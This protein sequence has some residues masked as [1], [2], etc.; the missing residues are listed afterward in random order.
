MEKV[1]GDDVIVHAG[2]QLVTLD[3]RLIAMQRSIRRLWIALIA[4]IAVQV[5]WAV[6]GPEEFARIIRSLIDTAV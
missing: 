3:E 5:L 6:V 4:W 2:D 1:N